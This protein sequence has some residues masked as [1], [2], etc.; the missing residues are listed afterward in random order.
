MAGKESFKTVEEYRAYY[1][2]YRFNNREK[3]RLYNYEYNRKW[4]EEH[5]MEHDRARNK[6]ASAIRSGTLVK[7][8]CE[9]CGEVKSQGHHEDYSKPLEVIW[10]CAVHH[11][12][13]HMK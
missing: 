6:V 13:K 12:E 4:R 5:G 2:A 10:L 8:P 7:L 3:L 1:R 11:K 9:V